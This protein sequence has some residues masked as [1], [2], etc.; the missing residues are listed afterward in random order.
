MDG[1]MVK[2]KAVIFDPL[3]TLV[4]LTLNSRPY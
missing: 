2:I 4:E 3:R 1:S